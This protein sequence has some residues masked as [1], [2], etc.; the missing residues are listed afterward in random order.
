VGKTRSTI[1][2]Y[3][4]PERLWPFVVETTVQIINSLTLPTTANPGSRSPQEQIATALNM[5]ESA[6]QPY[7]RHFRAYFCEAYYYV[8]PQKRTNSDKFT[9]RA[10]KGRLIGY[11]D[12]HGKIYWIWNPATDTIVRASAVRFNE[13][14]DFK[15]DDDVEDTEYE[16]IFADT[17]S[18][19]EE[20]VARTQE[21]ITL[22]H[23]TGKEGG[24]GHQP[25]QQEPQQQEPQQQEPHQQDPDQ[26]QD[27][28]QRKECEEDSIVVWSDGDAPTIQ[29]PTPQPTPE[30]TPEPPPP[31]TTPGPRPEPQPPDDNH[32]QPLDDDDLREIQDDAPVPPDHPLAPYTGH[33]HRQPDEPTTAPTTTRPMGGSADQSGESIE[34]STTRPRRAKAKYGTSS[35]E[36]YYAKLAKGQ[37]PGQS[38]Y[39]AHLVEPPAPAPLITLTL[40]HVKAVH[41]IETSRRADFPQNYRQ[42]TRLSNFNDYWF[43]AMRQQDDSLIAKKVYDLVPKRQGMTVLP[44][45]WVFDEKIDPHT[46]TTTA[47]ARWVVCGNFDQGSWNAQDVYAAVVNSVTVK[48]FFALVAVQD[49]ECHQFDFKTAFLNAP[50]PDGAEYYVEPPPGLGKPPGYVCKL[51][52]ALYGLRQSPLY[53]FLAIKP[54]MESLGFEALPSDLCLFR[55]KGLNILI[56]L[57][58]DDLL[59]A[60][61]NVESINSIRDRLRAIYDLNEIGEVRRFL[62]FDVIRDRAARNIFISQSSYIKTL[63][64]KVNMWDCSPAT[65][66]WPSKFELPTAWEPLT[67]EQKTCIKKTG[68]LN[69]ITCGTR[70]DISY[71]VSRLCEADSGP[72]QAH[73]D[74]T[75]HLFRYLRGTIDEGLEFG[76]H[77]NVDDLKLITFAD[78]SWADQQ[79]SRHSTGGHVVFVAGGP[80]LWKTKKQTFVALS[81]TEAE[82][83]NLTPAG[84][85]TLWVAKILEDC[86]V[87]QSLPQ[88]VY[89]D[90]LNAYLTVMNPLNVARTRCIDIRYKWIIEQVQRGRLK[91]SHIKGIEMAAD[92]LTKP[93]MREKHARFVRLLGMTRKKAPWSD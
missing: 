74:L 76:G 67:T 73:L 68:S 86:G 41:D 72:S 56:V 81:T 11:A 28:L 34:G 51:N 48:T 88:I 45:K 57:Y 50:I 60:A 78:A 93:L 47:R 23:P 84:Q 42:A 70:P 62:G 77:L 64:K 22:D 58:V 87:P 30:A 52:K 63:L 49:L 10:Q 83:T 6:Q 4:I 26:Q 55:H 19:E 2:A 9:A 15:P 13:G 12:L 1:I 33:P 91:V 38:F 8:K 27:Q 43:P 40:S 75:K 90:S 7:I 20:V 17:T 66:P 35:D 79:P 61:A 82:F 89:T 14:P 59:I 92:G 3:K 44:S 31:E 69:W 53:W 65:T 54:V 24:L 36:G 5:P 39:A 16:A 85:S 46:G 25:H 37:L 18:E 32:L 21:S 29:L 71:T 80:V